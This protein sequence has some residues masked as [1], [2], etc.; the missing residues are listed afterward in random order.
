MQNEIQIQNEDDYCFEQI[1]PEIFLSSLI[2]V[3]VLMSGALMK[4]ASHVTVMDPDWAAKL[5]RPRLKQLVILPTKA[6]W[7]SGIF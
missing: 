6:I 7:N 3:I 1:P 4:V 5:S 2:L